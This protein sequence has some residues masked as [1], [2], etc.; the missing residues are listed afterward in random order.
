MP[1]RQRNT[2][3]APYTSPYPVRH[4]KIREA[5]VVHLLP[6]NFDET[7]VLRLQRVELSSALKYEAL[8]YVWG[9]SLSPLQARVNGLGMWIT[10]NLDCAL[11]HLRFRTGIRTIWIDALCINQRNLAERNQ[12]VRMMGSIYAMA[13]RVVIWLG[14]ENAH[15]PIENVI[16]RGQLTPENDIRWITTLC[17][18]TER[19]WFTRVWVAQ[20]FALSHNEPIVRIGHKSMSWGSFKQRF[21]AATIVQMRNDAPHDVESAIEESSNRIDLIEDT[22]ATAHF[23]FQLI[24]T[25]LLVATDPRD[26]VYGLL[27][28]SDF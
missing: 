11:R 5:R 4:L 8:S 9:T 7:I 27:G 20:E 3:I 24:R 21:V 28:M 19:P 14:P 6:G 16:A 15:D 22:K 18:L 2:R 1:S 25:A 17:R 13:H 23:A 12:Q 10:E 26:K